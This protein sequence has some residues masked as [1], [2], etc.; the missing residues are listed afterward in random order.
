MRLYLDSRQEADISKQIK[1][2]KDK[3]TENPHEL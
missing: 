3:K 1:E 2:N